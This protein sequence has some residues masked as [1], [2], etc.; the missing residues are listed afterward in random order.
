MTK[1]IQLQKEYT[2]EAYPINEHNRQ[3]DNQSNWCYVFLN[4]DNRL[5]K[6]G[7][8]NDPYQRASNIRTASSANVFILCAIELI[9]ECDESADF[10]ERFLHGFFFEKRIVGEW[11]NLTTREYLSIRDLFYNTIEGDYIIDNTKEVL[12]A[13]PLKP[14]N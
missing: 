2:K 10:I 1:Y 8:T 7:K 6:I 5:C 12:N 3:K 9:P 14:L 11:F 13:K 4:L